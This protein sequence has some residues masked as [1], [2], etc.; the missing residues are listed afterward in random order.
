MLIECSKTTCLCVKFKL[1][2]RNECQLA[3]QLDDACIMF[4]HKIFHKVNHI[5]C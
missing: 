3:C 4:L 1:P 5:E 2:D